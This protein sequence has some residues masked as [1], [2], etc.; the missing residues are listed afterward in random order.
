MF[1]FISLILFLMRFVVFWFRGNMGRRATLE[2]VQ[3][4]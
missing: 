1:C 3:I 4:M 2:N